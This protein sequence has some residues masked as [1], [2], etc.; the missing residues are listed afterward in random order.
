MRKK[1]LS[2]LLTLVLCLSFLPVPARATDY[3]LWVA[4][5]QVK[6]ENKDDI[7]AAVTSAN[8]SGNT[9]TGTITFNP[10]TNTLT[11]NGATIHAL[12]GDS[13]AVIHSTLSGGLK[14]LLVGENKLY[15]DYT[16]ASSGATRGIYSETSSQELEIKGNT[17]KNTDTLTITAANIG[18]G[19]GIEC[20]GKLTVEKAA[21][22]VTCGTGYTRVYGINPEDMEVKDTASVSVTTGKCTNGPTRGIACQG[23]FKSKGT[24]TATAGDAG[25]SSEGSNDNSIGINTTGKFDVEGGTVSATGSVANNSDSCGINVGNGGEIKGGEVTATGGAANGSGNESRGICIAGGTLTVSGGT[26]TATGGT[27]TSSA[28]S[29]GIRLG[30]SSAGNM[31]ISGGTVTADGENFGVKMPMVL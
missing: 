30:I 26:V 5:V 24:V 18:T 9:A 27:P 4:G 16:N 31:T 12:N 7:A 22:T 1:L 25:E 15:Q 28:S 17:D 20:N 19:Y 3:N 2:V 21:L 13:G 8:T 11:L 29:I 14:I 23:D 6:D 10:T